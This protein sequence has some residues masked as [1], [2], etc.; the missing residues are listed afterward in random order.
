MLVKG[1][2]SFAFNDLCAMENN[3][4]VIWVTLELGDHLH[5]NEAG[6]LQRELNKARFIFKYYRTR[7]MFVAKMDTNVRTEMC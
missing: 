4:R 3:K 7:R 1:R 5:K 6:P 2:L